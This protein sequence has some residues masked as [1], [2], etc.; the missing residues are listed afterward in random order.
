MVP[1]TQLRSTCAS[2]DAA[3][4]ALTAQGKEGRAASA[5]RESDPNAY[6]T[7]LE[8]LMPL[9][10]LFLSLLDGGVGRVGQG[11]GKSLSHWETLGWS[12]GRKQ[13]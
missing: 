1:G 3:T 7:A 13:W 9:F 8:E 5:A 12:C 2:A 11:A 4:S 10:L 6:H